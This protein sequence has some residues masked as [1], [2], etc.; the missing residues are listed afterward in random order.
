VTVRV[1]KLA[2]SAPLGDLD[3][4]IDDADERTA[5][6]CSRL[7]S[8]RQ[9]VEQ[10]QAAVVS[11][12]TALDAAEEREQTDEAA[13]EVSLENARTS[14]VTAQN[15]LGTASNDTPAD[16]DAQEALVDDAAAAVAL[17]QKDLDETV[18]TAPVAGTVT[19]LN[20]NAGEVVSAPSAVTP[21][22]PG[23][24]APLPEETSGTGTGS[25][26]APGAGAFVVLDSADPFQLVVPF[27]EADA[28][29]IAPGQEV[30][31]AVDALPNDTLTGRVVSVAPSGQ[32]LSGIVSYYAT[33]VVEG[34]ADR[35]RDGQ[36]AEANVRVEAVDNVLRVPASAVRR[37]DGRPTVTVA[38]PDGQPVSVPFL[39]GLVGDDY[40][41]VRSGLTDGDQVELPQA[42]VTPGPEQDGPPDN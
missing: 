10:A 18:I 8:D 15:Q 2:A 41:E 17:A 40:V 16:T 14:V 24:T 25:A 19:A 1:V 13:G 4:D 34:G 23:G 35:L 7:L 26:G 42:T 36:T 37:E 27:E 9:A 28:A 21:L 31:V 39:A 6:A 12:R 38:G 11:S 5:P 32:D 33:V 3:D 30:D 29:R 20:G 22:A